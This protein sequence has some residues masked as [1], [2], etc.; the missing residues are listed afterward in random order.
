M[1][2]VATLEYLVFAVSE[3][4]P[5]KE[6]RSIEQVHPRSDLLLCALNSN[7]TLIREPC[8]CLVMFTFLKQRGRHR[9]YPRPFKMDYMET[10]HKS[11]I[12]IDSTLFAEKCFSSF[13][14]IRALANI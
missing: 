5:V 8:I 3:I 7:V 14:L 12:F 4:F 1:L 13:K 9:Y 6:N 11:G 2:I 10:L